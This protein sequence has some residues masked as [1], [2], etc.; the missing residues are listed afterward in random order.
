MLSAFEAFGES[1][2]VETCVLGQNG[3]D[4][5]AWRGSGKETGGRMG[6]I[7]ELDV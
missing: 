5:Y 1:G 3:G 7:K 4:Y 2:V 6:D